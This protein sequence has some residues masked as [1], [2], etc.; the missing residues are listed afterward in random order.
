MPSNVER[1][2]HGEYHEDKLQGIDDGHQDNRPPPAY[3]H[4]VSEH[5][6]EMGD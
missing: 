5:A 3:R 6:D 4:S 2:R 1:F